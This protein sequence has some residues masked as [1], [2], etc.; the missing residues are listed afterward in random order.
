MNTNPSSG[1]AIQLRLSVMMFLQFFVWG[2]WFVSATGFVNR[3]E[4]TGLTAAVYS[5]CPI[6]AILSPFFLG[7]VADRFFNSE[8]VLGAL[9]VLGGVFMILAP[10]FA[11]AY[12]PATGGSAFL[13]PFIL[14]LLAHTLC[15][16]PTLGL[17]TSLC[18]QNL[19][20]S[21]KQFPLIRVLGTIGWIAGNWA[22]S[23]LP[24]GDKSAHQ[25]TLAGGAAI[26]LG[27]YCLT[28]PR[29]PPPMAGRKATLGEILGLDSLQLFKNRAYVVFILCSLL[30]CIPLAGYFQQARNFVEAS[31]LTNPT[32]IISFGQM[33]EIFFMIAMPLFFV[34]LG[35][36]WMIAAG[37]AAWVLRYALF[38][39][40]ASSH[41]AWMIVAGVV[42][43]GICYDFFFVTG[44]I[45]V[46][47]FA[48]HHIRSQAQGFLVL[49][50]QGLGMLIGANVFGAIVARHTVGKVV[51]WQRVWTA[52]CLM[53]AAVLVLFVLLFQYRR[54][55]E[56]KG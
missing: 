9:H 52:P 22:V 33:S 16:M 4:M 5:V 35:V 19:K 44:M 7:L 47:K 50:T 11:S 8:R 24:D 1:G 26:L 36:K 23:Y 30:I 14:C 53:A 28:L 39:G 12:D 3:M 32:R 55:E 31:G 43:H 17:S 56:A 10:R 27:L 51:D 29:T 13:H 34:R 40:A 46:D 48:P 15:Y 25:F 20:S 18:F 37:M 49:V 2:S 41:I 42:L 54:T 21:E 6:A 38:A 45:Y